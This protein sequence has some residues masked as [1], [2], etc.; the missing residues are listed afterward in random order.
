[1][2][3]KKLTG[4]ITRTHDLS[5]TAR[6]VTIT[7][8][9]SLEFIAGSF[10]NI[11]MNINGSTVRRAYS[12]SSS[13]HDQKEIN[14]SVRR[15]INGTM[16][17]RFW[18]T[19]IVGTKVDIMGPLGLNTADKMHHSRIFLFA[20]GVGAG[21]VK[22]LADRFA[23]S[24]SVQELTI[25]TGSRNSQDII[26]QTYFDELSQ[27]HVHVTHVISNKDEASSY[28]KGYI[29]DHISGLN[30]NHA[31][32]YVC[33]QEKACEEL[34]AKIKTSHPDDCSFFVEGFH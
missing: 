31:D 12:I 10:I 29:Q 18:N 2:N 9:E 7:L 1:M 16:S 20:F 30:F 33:G 23:H 27:K 17:P 15:S 25:F 26:H 21:V 22:S 13:E 3:I 4:T 32:V 11:F 6:E 28:P 19:D 24:S 5:P 34:V 14:I 8:S